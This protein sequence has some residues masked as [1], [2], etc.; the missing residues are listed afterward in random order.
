MCLGHGD[1]SPDDS[2]SHASLLGSPRAPK[3]GGPSPQ[4]SQPS[5]GCPCLAGFPRDELHGCRP[6]LNRFTL[7][8]PPPPPSV[9]S[10]A[11]GSSSFFQ[12]DSNPR[13]KV[14][15]SSWCPQNR[16]RRREWRFS[17]SHISS[18]QGRASTCESWGEGFFEEAVEKDMRRMTH[19]SIGSFQPNSE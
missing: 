1:L 6:C 4:Q 5:E 14:C 8:Q 7:V 9:P 18:S 10:L 12:A 13:P 19:L 17:Q 11:P 15:P 16:D 3:G 2:L